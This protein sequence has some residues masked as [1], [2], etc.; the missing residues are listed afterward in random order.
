[1]EKKQVQ[2]KIPIIKL[3]AEYSS[4][5][6]WGALDDMPIG[7][8]S[9]EELGIS[10]KLSNKIYSWVAIY[11]SWYLKYDFYQNEKVPIEEVEKFNKMG[12][13][14]LKELQKELEGKYNVYLIE[15]KP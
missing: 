4:S 8:L 15:E 5:G 14:I 13:E 7:E 10:E 12:R 2:K 3:M 9:H 6:L 1:M 11:E